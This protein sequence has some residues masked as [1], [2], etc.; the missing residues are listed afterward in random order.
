V[1]TPAYNNK[2]A[3][4]LWDGVLVKGSQEIIQILQGLAGYGLDQGGG[5]ALPRAYRNTRPQRLEPI[6]HP[7]I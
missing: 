1:I 7:Q 5:K 6:F 2:L 3:G 4:Q